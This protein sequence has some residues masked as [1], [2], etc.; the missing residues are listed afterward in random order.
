MSDQTHTGSYQNPVIVSSSSYDLSLF[1][2]SLSHSLSLFPQSITCVHTLLFLL[3]FTPISAPIPYLSSFADSGLTFPFPVLLSLYGH[4]PYLALVSIHG[5]CAVPALHHPLYIAV[6]YCLYFLRLCQLWILPHFTRTP[7]IVISTPSRVDPEKLCL[8]P[9]V[10]PSAYPSPVP[11]SLL[12][13][14]LQLLSGTLTP[15][16]LCQTRVAAVCP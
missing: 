7:L 6:A 13:R 11:T 1:S 2:C 14:P 16:L 8:F 9:S 12:P 3:I 5:L 15:G 4:P 10:S